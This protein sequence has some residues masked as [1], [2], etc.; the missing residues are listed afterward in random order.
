MAVYEAKFKGCGKLKTESG[1]ARKGV[2]NAIKNNDLQPI[3]SLLRDQ[4]S[5]IVPLIQMAGSA[6]AAQISSF[7]AGPS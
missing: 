5:R 1:R 2:A 7:F 4:S 6:W 3:F